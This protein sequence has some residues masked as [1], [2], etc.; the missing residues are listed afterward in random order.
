[1][2][3]SM[4]QQLLMEECLVLEP[5]KCAQMNS[6]T[7]FL[8]LTLLN[9]PGSY[10]ATVFWDVSRKTVVI[11]LPLDCLRSFDLRLSGAVAL[12]ALLRVSVA[13]QQLRLSVHCALQQVSVL[14]RGFGAS[15]GTTAAVGLRFGRMPGCRRRV[16]GYI[17]NVH[18][19]GDHLL[20]HAAD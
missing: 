19:F 7:V 6:V 20:A 4:L 13:S 5:Q 14:F 18:A 3:V 16:Q 10:P 8:R 11:P 1:M 17:D 9:S 15:R 12:P 2:C